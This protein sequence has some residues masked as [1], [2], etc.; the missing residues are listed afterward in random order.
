MSEVNVQIGKDLIQPII[1]AKIQAAI[2]DALSGYEGLVSQAIA[3]VMNQ[4]VN[5]EGKRD[6]YDSYNKYPF[7]EVIC[8][9]RIQEAVRVSLDKWLASKQPQ[10]EAAVEKEMSRRT[11]SLARDFVAGLQNSIKHS[12]TTKLDVKFLSQS[13]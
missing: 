10:I 9:Q 12:W 1:E 7:I 6:Q 8:Q 11:G 3:R 13:E 5:H 2:V 4:K